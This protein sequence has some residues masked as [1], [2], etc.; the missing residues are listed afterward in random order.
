MPAQFVRTSYV[1]YLA[2]GWACVFA[3]PPL[4]E[5]LSATALALLLIGGV[6]YTVGVVFHLVAAPA[7]PQRHLARLRAGRLGLPLRRRARRRGAS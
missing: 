4:I 1:L 3:L 5:A 6:L 2:Q 7:L